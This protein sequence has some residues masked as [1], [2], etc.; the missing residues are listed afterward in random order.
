[1]RQKVK[2]FYNKIDLKLYKLIIIF[3]GK[4]SYA[5]LQRA[6]EQS[7]SIT[8]CIEKSALSNC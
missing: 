1:M 7:L 2:L 3:Y 8:L 4:H 5:A 6:K